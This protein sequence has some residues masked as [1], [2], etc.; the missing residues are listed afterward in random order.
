MIV[1]RGDALLLVPPANPTNGR[2][3]APDE[4]GNLRGP[5][6]LMGQHQDPSPLHDPVLSRP[7]P[8]VF[9][10]DLEVLA[11]QNDVL[12]LGAAHG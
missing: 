4:G 12:W 10:H 9:P 7:S 8:E 11:D 2:A 6:S 5:V 3:V 1:Q